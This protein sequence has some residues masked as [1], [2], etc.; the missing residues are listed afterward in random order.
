MGSTCFIHSG[1]Y[2]G[3]SAEPKCL[4]SVLRIIGLLYCL[5]SL[6][7][8]S[9]Q[10]ADR[11]TGARRLP[12]G[13]HPVR[14]HLRAPSIRLKA[15]SVM[16]VIYHGIAGLA[17]PPGAPSQTFQDLMKQNGLDYKYKR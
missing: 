3:S 9:R 7:S 13:R 15:S 8:L 2:S 6:L 5:S 16:K 1:R 17:K 11:T 10:T 12:F 4:D 14:W